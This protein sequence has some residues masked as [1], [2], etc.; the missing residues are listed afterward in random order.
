MAKWFDETILIKYWEDRCNKYELQDG[1]KIKSAK[2]N[3]SFG[4]YPDISENYLNDNTVV[5]AEIEW[6]TT[7]FDNHGHDIEELRKN[8]GFLI[9]YNQ[10]AG[11]PV[12]QVQIEKEDFIEWFK[13]SAE[14]L[15]IETLQDIEQFAKKSK[16]PQIFLFYIP[17]GGVKNFEIALN[18]GIW[19]FPDGKSKR[20]RRGLEKIMQIK[21]GDILIFVKEWKPDHPITGG[22]VKSEEFTGSFKEVIGVAVTRGYYKSNKEIWKDGI[23]PY[24]VEFRKEILFRGSEIP[25][26]EKDLGKSLHEILRKLEINGSVEKIDSSLILKLMSLCTKI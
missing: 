7:S 13:E 2:R 8:N 15:C 11:F 22:R 12:E 10:N 4:K 17:G 23:Y 5:P 25:C 3:P 20:K 24:R 9:V 14:N 1:R 18:N 16:E 21:K 19:G 6:S 26:Y